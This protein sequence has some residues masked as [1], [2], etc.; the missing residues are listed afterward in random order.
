[1][2]ATSV[3]SD[4]IK[5]ARGAAW[6]D[7]NIAP[8]VVLSCMNATALNPPV[9]P[10]LNYSGCRGGTSIYLYQWISEHGITDET[11]AI[12]QARGWSNGLTCL[13][14]DPTGEMSWCKTCDP[15][16]NCY[17]P[18]AYSKYYTTEYKLV[19]GTEGMMNAL[20]DGPITCAV[21]ATSPGFENFTGDG[22]YQ[23]PPVTNLA[24][25]DHEISLYGYGT[26]NG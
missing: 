21:E 22:I 26:E 17:V 14:E 10:S 25:L 24:D 13:E 18:D 4:K 7:V 8:Q 12:Y 15:S 20:Q 9:D 2:S 16:G 11:C 1:M 23:G 5:I 6:P 19:N 3:L